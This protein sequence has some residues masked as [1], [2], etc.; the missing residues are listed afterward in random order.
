MGGGTKTTALWLFNDQLLR[1]KKG[2]HL[3]KSTFNE[4]LTEIK[5]KKKL[6][7]TWD[8]LTAEGFTRKFTLQEKNLLDF[9]QCDQINSEV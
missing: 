1:W 8:W 5:V 7:P 3:L 2:G 4:I 9:T 6:I